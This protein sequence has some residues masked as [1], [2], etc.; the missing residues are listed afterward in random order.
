MKH[1]AITLALSLA[2]S[3][4]F[5]D[6]AVEDAPPVV[7]FVPVATAPVLPISPVVTV[8]TVKPV[9]VEL[10]KALAASVPDPETIRALVSKLTP[11]SIAS[12]VVSIS[13]NPAALSALVAQLSPD[14]LKKMQVALFIADVAAWEKFTDMLADAPAKPAAQKFG[15]TWF[16]SN[17]QE[18]KQI[19]NREGYSPAAL[20][21]AEAMMKR[22]TESPA[23]KVKLNLPQ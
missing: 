23:P 15:G 16:D 13:D 21:K 22:R 2:S 9:A 7:P 3:A 5:A 12:V 20:A 14:K 11:E 18:L 8:W 6:D 19:I 1:V 10:L 17:M 4:L